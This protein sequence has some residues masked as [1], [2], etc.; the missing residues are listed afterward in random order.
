MNKTARS[1][2]KD[3]YY[4][5]LP[6]VYISFWAIVADVFLLLSGNFCA[7]IFL[8]AVLHECGHIAAALICGCKNMSMTFMPFGA[9]ISFYG[10]VSYKKEAFIMF[11]GAGANLICCFAALLMMRIFKTDLIFFFF[12]SLILAAVNLLPV[13][14]LDG[15]KLL[16]SLLC[17]KFGLEKGYA[18]CR[19]AERIFFILCAAAFL[20][21]L[22][23]QGEF[24]HYSLAFCIYIFC[25]CMA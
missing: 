25:L 3:R 5:I 15:G 4:R 12:S 21:L 9:K 8:C 6:N 19:A 10:T 11:F 18:V 7:E 23:L 1:F 24:S 2:L 20:V 17:D 16:Y 14:A 22:L 13:S